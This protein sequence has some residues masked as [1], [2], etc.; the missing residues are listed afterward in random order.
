[1]RWEVLLKKSFFVGVGVCV[2]SLCCLLSCGLEEIYY[3]DYIFAS[4]YSDTTVATVS[5]PDTSREGYDTPSRGG[6]FTNFIIY[7]R[8]YI[9]SESPVGAILETSYRRLINPTLENNYST[10]YPLT[11]ITNKNPNISNLETTFNN[12][13][14]YKLALEGANIDDILGRGS[15]GGTLEFDFMDEKKSNRPK[16]I[17]TDINKNVYEKTMLRA[18]EGQ[19]IIFKPEPEDR[20]FYNHS[21]LHDNEKAIKT[22]NA[23]TVAS[24][25]VSNPMYT[26]VLMYIAAEGKSQEMPPRTIYSQPTFVGIFSL[27]SP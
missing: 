27:P 12:Y 23:D 7:Y 2:V 26:Y 9:S 10:L 20:Y 6:Y 24:Q 19:N 16:L 13:D 8:I 17:L 22:V 15:L 3:L 18:T 4:N 1:M 11:D 14:F 25:K 21:S 5:L